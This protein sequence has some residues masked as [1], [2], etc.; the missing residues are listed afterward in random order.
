MILERAISIFDKIIQFQW[1]LPH[2][3]YGMSSTNARILS[4]IRRA[5]LL[6]NVEGSNLIEN[7]KV[8]QVFRILSKIRRLR[9]CVK[10]KID[11]IV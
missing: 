4:K 1:Y 8:C 11:K 7:K 5:L 3:L 10:K 9:E 2:F 6:W